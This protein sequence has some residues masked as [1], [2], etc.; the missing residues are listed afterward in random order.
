[1]Q[2]SVVFLKSDEVVGFATGHLQPIEADLGGTGFYLEAYGVAEAHRGGKDF[3][4]GGVVTRKSLGMQLV[5]IMCWHAKILGLDVLARVRVNNEGSVR[6]LE[7]AAEACGR[8]FHVVRA[9]RDFKDV[10]PEVLFDKFKAWEQARKG[11]EGVGE[12]TEEDKTMRG[13]EED[14]QDVEYLAEIQEMRILNKEHGVLQ[15]YRMPLKQAE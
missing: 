4:V 6:C 8:D 13:L 2:F 10:K 7:R 1:M 12:E 11:K 5:L 3:E 14:Y 15:L 9:D